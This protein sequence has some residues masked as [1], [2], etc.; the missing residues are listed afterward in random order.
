MWTIV[1]KI[2]SHPI[3]ASHT[4]GICIY[5]KCSDG[6]YFEPHQ[7][8]IG[9]DATKKFLQQILA[10][11][12]IC[13]QHLPKNIPLKQLTQE[14]WGEYNNATNCFI[15]TKP[16]KSPDKNVCNHNHLTSKY[17]G[18]AHNTCNLNYCFH[19]IFKLTLKLFMG[20]Y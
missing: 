4:I 9:D 11:T 20:N 5:I 17:R 18:P 3:P 8:N 13:R 16:F 6:Q 12:T 14:Q 2:L 19:A 7:V 10:M 1:T 15:C